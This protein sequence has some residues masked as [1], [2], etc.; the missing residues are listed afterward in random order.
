MA[1]HDGL[2]SILE[3]I[4]GELGEAPSIRFLSYYEMMHGVEAVRFHV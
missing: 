2:L 4:R 3:T 1:N